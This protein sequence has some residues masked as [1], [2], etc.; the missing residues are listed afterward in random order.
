MHNKSKFGRHLPSQ[1][2]D[3]VDS[4]TIL[5]TRTPHT[6]SKRFVKTVKGIEKIDF[7]AGFLFGVMEPQVVRDINDL[8]DVLTALEAF[9]TMLA[10]RGAPAESANSGSWVRRT[11]SGDVGN[12]F[13][14]AEGRHWI[15]IDFDKITVP[16]HLSLTKDPA[17]VCEHLVT[18]LPAEFRDATYHWTMSSSA[19]MGDQT[20]VSMHIWFWLVARTP[21][22]ALK[23]W[24]K[25]VNRRAGLKLIDDALFQHVQA[26]Y[27][28]R[29]EFSGLQDP[30]PKRSGLQVKTHDAVDL[31]LP[32]PNAQPTR[33][34]ARGAG[35]G[36]H[37]VRAGA[38]FEYHLS[39][40]GDHDGGDGFHRPI[41][42]A[43]A[44]HVAT[45]GAQGTD[46]EALF[47]VVSARVLSADA[48][49]HDRAYVERMASRDHIVPAIDSAL[50]KFGSQPS[51]RRKAKLHVGTPSHFESQPISV[52]EAQHQLAELAKLGL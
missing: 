19:G 13:T 6:A 18:L 50:E 41:I 34:S 44:S 14:P 1:P 3:T 38:G 25:D 23:A 52:T 24:A 16:K 45:H 26:H 5:M 49:N 12:F 35:G 21:D 46:V 4:V 40:I 39:L 37:H 43:V 36:N 28:A 9:P 15:L 51:P 2:S 32:T 30:F 7:N 11:G 47:E 8:S 31:I 27:T 17:G 22:Q 20:K 33:R 42:A 48:K 10:I 29:P